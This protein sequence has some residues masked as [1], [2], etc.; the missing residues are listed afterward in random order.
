MQEAEEQPGESLLQHARDALGVVV[1]RSE[2]HAHADETE[3]GHVKDADSE[4][5]ADLRG[6]LKPAGRQRGD[7]LPEEG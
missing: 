2:D 7:R 6:E 5:E 3:A 1:A 4:L